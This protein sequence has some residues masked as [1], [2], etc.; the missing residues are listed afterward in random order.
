[1]RGDFFMQRRGKGGACRSGGFRNH[2]ALFQALGSG[3]AKNLFESSSPPRRAFPDMEECRFERA[4]L[5]QALNIRLEH[6]TEDHI[7]SA[8]MMNKG[9]EVIEA[10]YCSR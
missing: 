8:S 10:S 7:D 2:N 4:T 1:V 3:I 9:L 6:G 5:A